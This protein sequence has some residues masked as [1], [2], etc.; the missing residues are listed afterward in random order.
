MALNTANSDPW[1]AER[2]QLDFTLLLFTIPVLSWQRNA[3]RCRVKPVFKKRV[4]ITF[5]DSVRKSKKKRNL[6]FKKSKKRTSREIRSPEPDRRDNDTVS[7]PSRFFETLMPPFERVTIFPPAF[8]RTSNNNKI[9]VALLI[10][11]KI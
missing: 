8:I 4:D 5:L 11:Y 1:N 6:R 7:G 3:K 9:G 10:Q 2:C